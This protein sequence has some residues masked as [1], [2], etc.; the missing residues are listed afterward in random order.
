MP[1]RKPTVEDVPDITALIN[2]DASILSRSQHYVFENLRDFVIAEE[3][4]EIVG[5]GSLHVLWENI[6]EIRAVTMIENKQDN[7]LFG[8]MIRLLLDDAQNLGIQKVV[9]LTQ[10]PDS[11]V[12]IGFS[13]P[14]RQDVPQVVW[15]EC[16][17]CVYFPDCLEE[18]V[19]YD[20]NGLNQGGNN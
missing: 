12:N 17:N 16:I 13:A 15:K 5:C 20:L 1:F 9:V 10:K 7:G 11:F 2:K 14:Q 3:S 4:G 18:P 19:I 6:A 8:Q